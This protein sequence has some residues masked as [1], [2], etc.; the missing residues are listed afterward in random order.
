VPV[1]R[2]KDPYGGRFAV[3]PSG[4]SVSSGY[5]QATARLDRDLIRRNIKPYAKYGFEQSLNALQDMTDQDRYAMATKAVLAKNKVGAKPSGG[6]KKGG[7]SGGGSKGG[8]K[9]TTPK[10]TTKPKKKVT[11]VPGPKPK[12]VR[13]PPKPVRKHLPP[14]PVPKKPTLPPR[15]A[16]APKPHLPPK[17]AP[18][19]KRPPVVPP[20]GA[21]RV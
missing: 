12:G 4:S 9:K 7:S 10:T 1:S 21:I 19:P 13:Q 3:D 5:Q 15:G 2:S 8:S 16:A 20:S 18:K 11:N 6:S 17:P 14:K